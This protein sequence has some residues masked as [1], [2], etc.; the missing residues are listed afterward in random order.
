M[1]TAIDSYYHHDKEIFCLK[2]NSKG[3]VESGDHYYI[4][5]REMMD[6]DSIK[7]NCTNILYGE[8]YIGRE[9]K[10]RV[11]VIDEFLEKCNMK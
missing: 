1:K 4:P 8:W 6:I 3:I 9:E 2:R 7:M 5:S 10:K 11:K